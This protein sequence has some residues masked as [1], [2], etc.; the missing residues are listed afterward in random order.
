MRKN[1]DEGRVAA[2]RRVRVLQR[3]HDVEADEAEDEL[4]VVAELRRG[5]AHGH[6]LCCVI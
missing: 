3:G 1:I 5:V 6:D 4:L 2:E